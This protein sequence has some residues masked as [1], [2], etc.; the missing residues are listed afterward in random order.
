MSS[1]ASFHQK[2][3][4]AAPAF[5]AL[6]TAPTP[7]SRVGLG[8]LPTPVHAWSPPG[9][10]GLDCY[11]KRDDLSGCDVSGNKVHC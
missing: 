7:A 10:H 1:V 8:M 9:F 3:P 4:Y 11:I 5:T 6:L 2:T